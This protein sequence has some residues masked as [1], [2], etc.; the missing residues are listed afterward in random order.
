MPPKKRIIE[1]LDSKYVEHISKSYN[2]TLENAIKYIDDCI[3]Q[4][5]IKLNISY[6]SIYNTVF[7]I[8]CLSKIL[9]TKKVCDQYTID[10]CVKDCNCFV[11][12]PYG[13]LPKKIKDVDKIN[14]DP[15]KYVITYLGKLED[16]KKIV[17]VASYL[18]YNF[19]GG[20]L[21]DNSFDALE[22]HLNKKE[23]LKGRR[24]EKIGAL[25]I[26]KIRVRLKYGMPSLAKIKPGTSECNRFL[27]YFY[28]NKMGCAWSLKL[29]GVSGMAIYK[30]KKLI[31]LNS[32]GANPIYG[33]DVTYLKE[34]IKIPKELK[35]YGDIVVRGEFI[36]PKDVWE[37][38]YKNEYSNA[39]AF[40][41]GKV[42]AGFIS[43]ALNDI[44][45][46]AYEIMS[47]SNEDYTPQPSKAFKI[48][49]AEGFIT[50]DNGVLY[51]PTVFQV[52][53]LYKNKRAESEY[54]IDGLVLSIDE[55]RKGSRILTSDDEF[56]PEPKETVAFK[57]L[58]EEQIRSTKII[59]IEWNISRYG[60]YVPVAI[61]EAVYVEGVR[62]T[63]ATAHNARHVSD[64]SMGKGT[65]VKVARS[66]DVI[67]QIKDV[68]VDSTISPI[69][70][71]IY[72]DGGYE[73]HWDKS[74]II[75]DDIENN[76][77]VHIKRIIHFFET[78]NV[79]GLGP[80]TIE[81]LYD[82]GMETAESIVK[83]P[84]SEFIKIKG[85]GKKKAE[86]Y[87]ENIRKIM[88][89]TPPDRFILA[90]TT[91]KSGLGRKLLKD[92]F[93]FIPNLLLL[94]SKEITDYFTKNKIPG[95][96]PSRIKTISEGIPEF[97]SYLDS[98][99]RED[100]NKAIHYYI[101]RMKELDVKGR[102]PLING[103]KFVTTGF[104]QSFDVDL[105]DYISDHNGT[106]VKTVTSD[107]SAVICGN[108][109]GTTD[110]MLNAAKLG[111][112]VLS[113][114]E[115]V[116]YYNVPLKKFENTHAKGSNGD[117]GSTFL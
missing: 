12:E 1:S 74:D 52:I 116:K 105:E 30:N 24:F 93:K 56:I 91:F 23:K 5:A 73:W 98:F 103:F 22:W 101:D 117:E 38:K 61:Y 8:E 44:E 3:Q 48:L 26:E 66:G 42:N 112:K 50:V 7:S 79:P 21:T 85:I 89:I 92:L 35:H 59:N 31:E 94:N 80:K 63:R 102:N 71:K 9:V 13:C 62:L 87:Y 14:E 39:R 86:G 10:E 88:A 33:G 45:F 70:P 27:E 29:D 19:D 49:E 72:D 36:L 16:L 114:S 6:S 11:L 58:L 55:S 64:W 2:I 95:F 81:K 76:R 65:K 82:S 46:V 69:F 99:M 78:L 108:V 28:G 4:T 18:Y 75:L 109:M 111:V 115:F 47:I 41:S 96:G 97:K 17:H 84:V 106:F 83:S 32:G 104:L 107:V 20:G 60:R 15:D 37:K 90:S 113:L 51:S 53:E 40:V 77:E 110:K 67:P 68:T 100:I 54:F 25:P 43:S 34:Y 57:M